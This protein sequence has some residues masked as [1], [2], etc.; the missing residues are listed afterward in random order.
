[1]LKAANPSCLRLKAHSR[2]EKNYSGTWLIVTL[3]QVGLAPKAKDSLRI[4]DGRVLAVRALEISGGIRILVQLDAGKHQINIVSTA[5][6][7]DPPYVTIRIG[8]P[9]A[10]LK[11]QPARNAQ[12]INRPPWARWPGISGEIRN[13]TAARTIRPRAL[14]KMKTRILT[15]ATGSIGEALSYKISQRSY[16]DA[17]F[18]LNRR[19]P[20]HARR[21]LR[22]EG[23]LRDAFVDISAGPADLRL[24]KQQIV[25]G[26]SVGLF[27]A[28]TVNAKDFREYILPDTE[29]IR[30]PQ[31]GA[32]LEYSKEGSHLELI[33]LAPKFNR[34]APVGSEFSPPF[35][36]P[37]GRLA[38][39]SFDA[40]QPS[41]K[42]KNTEL[43]A[44]LSR[45]TYGWDISAFYLYTW[46]K[47]PVFYRKFQPFPLPTYHFQARYERQNIVGTTL[48]KDLDPVVL[49][50]ETV[51]HFGR[52]LSI[53][54]EADDDGV[55]SLDSLDYLLGVDYTWQGRWR[56]NVQFMQRVLW[57]YRTGLF[58]EEALRSTGSVWLRG[59]FAQDRL[60]PE[61]LV[62]SS[63]ERTDALLRPKI[64]YH[65]GRRWRLAVGA[66]LFEGG[67]D[68]LFGFYDRNDRIFTDLTLYF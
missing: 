41:L 20:G 59:S 39:G 52:R 19:Y 32:D 51:H 42:I 37:P 8:P 11:P 36:L 61:L 47:S 40:E 1:M 17:V 30:I 56:M 63:L 12:G 35:P 25:W 50:A 16:Y 15:S 44:R 38:T 65:W 67:R 4:D 48:A 21:D 66:D 14:S 62:L 68:G 53:I 23:E 60:E 26:E 57:R 54:D 7:L 24:G 18:D 27:F 10:D 34:L 9:K 43:G 31:W 33:W 28:D 13:E 45:L 58:Q 2:L 22:L 3:A 6:C 55:A 46:D 5:D 49:R 29:Q 64:S